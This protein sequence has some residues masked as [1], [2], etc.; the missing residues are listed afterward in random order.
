MAPMHEY[1]V[2]DQYFPIHLQT[3]LVDSIRTFDVFINIQGKMVLY[4]TG[5]DRFTA[6]VRNNLLANR[7]MALYILKTD[8]AA[9]NRYIEKNLGAIL[10]NPALTSTERAD[11]AYTSITILSQSLFEN[12]RAQTIVRYKSAIFATMNY[13][14]REDGAIK[15]LIRLTSHD[16]NTYTHSVNVGIFAIGLA[17]ALLADDPSHN[18]NELASGFFLHDI[19][20]CFTPL[21]VLN[22]P[23][24]LTEEEWEIIRRHPAEGYALLKQMNALTPES[25]VIIMEHHERHDGKGYP[26]QL[27]GNQIHVYSKI[28]RIADVFDALTS[29]RP[30]KESKTPFQA[31]QTMKDE[32]RSEFDPYMFEQFVLLF[33]GGKIKKTLRYKQVRK[34][35]P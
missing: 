32:M 21:P 34:Y 2:D 3:I 15:N 14:M 19:G 4:H 11:I 5:G 26:R 29:M 8:R 1:H 18:M 25:R 17:K 35:I 20:K 6:E 16:F 24:P 9:Y 31:L 7:I 28:C 22:K 23:G 33:G 13:I 10:V 30:Y 12:P 27:S